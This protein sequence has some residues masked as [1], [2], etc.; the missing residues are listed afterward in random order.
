MKHF[1][2]IAILLLGA[3]SFADESTDIFQPLLG[4]YPVTFWNSVPATGKITILR[5]ENNIGYIVEGLSAES[6]TVPKQNWLT[7][8]SATHIQQ[9]G[10]KV[11][12][13]YENGGDHLRT[14]FEKVG[15][16]VTLV[17]TSCNQNSCRMMDFNR[18]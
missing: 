18:E 10:N 5:D 8:V 15:G 16:V 14:E 11:V 3:Q 6:S 1:G 2:L 7:P 13:T 9:V 17:S 4:D 12:Q